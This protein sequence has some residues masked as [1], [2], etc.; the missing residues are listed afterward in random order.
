VWSI[1]DI[2]RP[3]AAMSWEAAGLPPPSWTT[4]NKENGHAHL[5]WRLS[6]PVLINSPDMRLG[7]LRY[8]SGIE[9]MMHHRLQADPGFCGLLTKNPMH[10]DWECLRGP[11]QGY[12]L[13]E[14]AAHLPGIEKHFPRPRAVPEIGL[15]RNVALFDFLRN[16]AYQQIRYYKLDIRNF[17]AWQSHLNSRALVRNAEFLPQM[18]G[19]EVWHIAKSVAKWTWRRFDLAASDAQFSKLQAARG[20]ASGLARRAAREDAR[21]SAR[22]MAVQG[23]SSRAIAPILGVNQSTVSRWLGGD[24]RTIIR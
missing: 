7:P 16:Y 18:D 4:V 6:I 21:V 22:L 10:P 9:S 19:R 15:G 14:L 11:Q 3:D 23:Y 5:A 13:S 2:D 17:V 12:S 24:A 20:R 8:L 1:F